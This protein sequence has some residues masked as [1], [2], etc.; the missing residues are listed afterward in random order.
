LVYDWDAANPL[1]IAFR[2][3]LSGN[4]WDAWLLLVQRLMTVT[5]TTEPDKFI[6]SLNS[7]GQ[8]SVKSYCADLLNEHTIF[9]RKYILKLK[10]PLKIKIFMWFLHQKV[11]LTKDN[12]E[13]PNWN[14]C[15]KCAFTDS[16][17]SINHLFFECLLARLVCRVVFSTFNIV[18]P[19]NVMNMF[20]NWLNDVD[21]ITKA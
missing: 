13:K 11:I 17:E 21:K 4:N 3:V 6:W 16:N 15:P 14:G 7:L 18:P 2:R 9:L 1:N 10:V 20:R 19:A 8:F 12:L 5:L